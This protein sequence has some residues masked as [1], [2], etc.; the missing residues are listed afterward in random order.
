MLNKKEMEFLEKLEIT[1]SKQANAKTKNIKDK[2]L[3]SQREFHN[4]WL[5]MEKL[6]KEYKTDRTMQRERMKE[7]RKEDKNYGRPYYRKQ[8]TID[9]EKAIKEG[10]KFN[11]TLQW[12]K[13]NYKKGDD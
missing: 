2:L 7:R 1:L 11:K 13:E 6:E 9:K 3:I 5:I 12:Y 8:Y 10:K 4:F